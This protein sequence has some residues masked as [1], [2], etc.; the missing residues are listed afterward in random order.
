VFATIVLPGISLSSGFEQ[1]E[2]FTPLQFFGPRLTLAVRERFGGDAIAADGSLYAALN[3]TRRVLRV[4]SM[5]VRSAIFAE[6]AQ[7][8]SASASSSKET[9]LLDD[10][11][12]DEITVN[13]PAR[14]SFYG[15]DHSTDT[16]L[17][18]NK[19]HF[20]L[21]GSTGA[22]SSPQK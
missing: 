16:Q 13:S 7:G 14:L 5:A 9:Y 15:Q 21:M 19:R 17:P 1:Q 3:M 10:D 11:G 4:D 12:N 18:S 20:H 8:L 22:E 6:S 2:R